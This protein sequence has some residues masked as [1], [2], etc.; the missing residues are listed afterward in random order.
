ML[1]YHDY[2]AKQNQEI[3]K[4]Y[5]PCKKVYQKGSTDIRILTI[6]K[7]NVGLDDA[8]D[9]E[10]WNGPLTEKAWVYLFI[11][12]VLL[13]YFLFLDGWMDGMFV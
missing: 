10:M 2:F 6:L 3:S 8:V 1:T 7:K 12:L 11:Y 13:I 4:K 9:H 5:F